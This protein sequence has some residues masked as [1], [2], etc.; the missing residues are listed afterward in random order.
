MLKVRFIADN[1]LSRS[2][3]LM[4]QAALEENECAF[5]KFDRIGK[6]SFWNKNVAFPISLLFCD[7]NKVVKDIKYLDA[8]QLNS[9]SPS[10]YDIRYVVEAHVDAPN[11]HD[12][13]KGTK[14]VID[15][16]TIKFNG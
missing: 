5:F 10:S 6:H 15:G 1:Y 13:K 3:G 16:D 7:S 4:N 8:Q 12:I 14:V 9:V 11:K 2:L